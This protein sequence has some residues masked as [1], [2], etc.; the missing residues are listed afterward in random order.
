MASTF[1]RYFYVFFEEN[2]LSRLLK[3][4]GIFDV[5]LSV[6]VGVPYSD[7]NSLSAI[8][9]KYFIPPFLFC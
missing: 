3:K 7:T 9:C 5:Y 1:G 4:P 6:V 8:V 2:C